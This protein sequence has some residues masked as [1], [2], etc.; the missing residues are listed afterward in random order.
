VGPYLLHI[1]TS[2]KTCSVAISE[3]STCLAHAEDYSGE[4]TRVLNNLIREVLAGCQMQL[5]QLDGIVVNE[6][7]GSYTSLRIGVVAAKGL[8]YALD[9]PL[10]L[11]PGLKTIASAARQKHP[12]YDY[13]L[14]M[15]DA[16]R[17]EVYLAVYDHDLRPVTSIES[18]LLNNELSDR[19][20]LDSKKTI[21]AGSGAAK[22]N[23]FIQ[24]WEPVQVEIEMLASNMIPL[25]IELYN[26]SQ[27]TDC[28]LAQPFYLKL[29]N[30]TTPKEKLITR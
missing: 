28:S 1:E 6:G 21:I 14:A 29:P 25:A 27:F 20:K 11:I 22:W 7:P 26:S 3:G 17:D 2:A 8:S 19:L 4:H 18:V 23:L 15:V 30:I 10:I 16:R 12:D 13:C 5:N 9:K 24:N